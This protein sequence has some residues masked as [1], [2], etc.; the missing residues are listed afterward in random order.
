MQRVHHCGGTG[1]RRFVACT[2]AAAVA[3][4][5]A[6]IAG[7]SNAKDPPRAVPPTVGAPAAVAPITTTLATAVPAGFTGFTD[8]ADRFT[9]A[10]PATWRQVDPAS[11]GAE[12][13]IQEVVKRYPDFASVLGSGDLAAQGMRFIAVTGGGAGAN[14]VVRPAVGGR[15]SDLPRIGER[16][17]VQYE[18]LGLT[19]VDLGSEQLSGRAALRLNV[20][21]HL[22]G[23]TGAAP[24]VHEVQ[25]LIVAN[26]L[27]YILTLSGDDPQLPNVAA[28]LRVG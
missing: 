13:A 11:P 17:K 12:Q 18:S 10:V 19:V 28:T 6:L 27:I 5:V 14:V 1:G 15:D 20:D 9:I 2:A 25:H 7:C 26:D 24:T 4:A 21:A 22:G 3:V 23:A 8:A 16:L